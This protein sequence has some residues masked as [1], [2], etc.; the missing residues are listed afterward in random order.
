VPPSLRKPP[1]YPAAPAQY[2]VGGF[3]PNP[4]FSPTTPYL[5]TR[6]LP[7]PLINNV[8]NPTTPLISTPKPCLREAQ[9]LPLLSPSP[10]QERGGG[11]HHPC[12]AV[13][14]KSPP[15]QQVVKSAAF[16]TVK[17]FCF[18]S[19]FTYSYNGFRHNIL[20]IHFA[21]YRG[22]AGWTKQPA[23]GWLLQYYSWYMTPTPFSLAGLT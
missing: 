8:P 7:E 5:R 17:A 14:G 18:D 2:F 23:G 3:L 1:Y 11:G 4:S 6:L 22:G 12:P 20:S 15:E 19:G 9:S 13:I 10:W 21:N 16:K